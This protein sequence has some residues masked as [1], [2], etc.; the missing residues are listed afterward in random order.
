MSLMESALT[1]LLLATVLYITI[2]GVQNNGPKFIISV[3]YG[4]AI[5]ALCGLWGSLALRPMAGAGP[6]AGR[7]A[8]SAVRQVS[9]VR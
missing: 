3:V 7:V 4:A 1:F 8:D 2:R 9:S 5:A 6:V